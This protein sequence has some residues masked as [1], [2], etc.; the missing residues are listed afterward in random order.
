MSMLSRI[1][2]IPA[3]LRF[4]CNQNN[5]SI[6]FQILNDRVNILN[7][8]DEFFQWQ[9]KRKL[10]GMKK[11]GGHA[12]LRRFNELILLLKLTIVLWH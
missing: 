2:G 3:N 1:N 9:K 8:I 4:F 11:G 7:F 12:I 6:K 5:S 10:A